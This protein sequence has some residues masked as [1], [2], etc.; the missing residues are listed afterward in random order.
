VTRGG[1]PDQC[2]QHLGLFYW[3]NTPGRRGWCHTYAHDLHGL[4]PVAGPG[5][6]ALPVN[7]D[8]VRGTW[9]WPPRYGVE[10]YDARQVQDLFRRIAAELDAGRPI[11]PLIETGPS[12]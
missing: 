9:F 10:G 4:R 7:G 1:D 5:S 2:E 8:Q 6:N 12:A 11:G 3:Q